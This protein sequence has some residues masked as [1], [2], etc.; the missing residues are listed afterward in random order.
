MEHQFQ[1]SFEPRQASP[2]RGHC[3]CGQWAY[4][5]TSAALVHSAF[6]THVA[7]AANADQSSGDRGP[8][9]TPDNPPARL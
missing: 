7:V 4:H 8:L 3:T 2:Y 1:P 5:A 6:D 9:T